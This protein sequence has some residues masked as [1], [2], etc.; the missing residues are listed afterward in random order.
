VP[1]RFT[2]EVFAD[3]GIRGGKI[4]DNGVTNI[5]AE[6]S[7]DDGTAQVT[8]FIRQGASVR[9]DCTFRG[10]PTRPFPFGQVQY[11]QLYRVGTGGEAAT[12][13][14]EIPLESF[15]AGNADNRA[16]Y[17]SGTFMLT[18]DE[19]PGGVWT[20]AAIVTTGLPPITIVVTEFF[21]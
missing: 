11:L 3:K 12:K 10:D 17:F 8:V 19:P 13:I 4:Q 9:I 6:K 7:L 2:D 20:Y 16:T 18:I 1:V 5:W 14:D 15:F 21:K